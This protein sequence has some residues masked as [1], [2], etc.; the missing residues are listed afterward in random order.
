MAELDVLAERLSSLTVLEALDLVAQLEQKWRVSARPPGTYLIIADPPP[1]RDPYVGISYTVSLTDAG[2]N[3]IVA[4][5]AFR[6]ARP[7]IGVAEASRLIASLPQIV[8]TNLSRDEALR[9]ERI[10]GYERLSVAITERTP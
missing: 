7:D 8:A 6:L 1:L 5:K 4:I 2:P 9:I 3:P 10:F